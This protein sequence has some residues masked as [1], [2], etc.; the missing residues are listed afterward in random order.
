MRHM[1]LT[2]PR[3]NAV[4]IGEK[5]LNQIFFVPSLSNSPLKLHPDGWDLLDFI[6]PRTRQIC[7]CDYR[8]QIVTLMTPAWNLRGAP[9][10]HRCRCRQWSD[11]VEVVVPSIAATSAP[12]GSIS[13]YT[14]YIRGRSFSLMCVVLVGWIIMY[15]SQT[16]R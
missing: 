10:T 14:C 4:S 3:A 12:S 6:P 8:H 1:G 16:G 9:S 7:Y 13:L 15:F 2:R 5:L 11:E